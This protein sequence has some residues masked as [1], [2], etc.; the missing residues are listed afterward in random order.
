MAAVPANHRV[1]FWGGGGRPTFRYS[2][3]APRGTPGTTI[4][5]GVPTEHTTPPPVM[6]PSEGK[7]T[8]DLSIYLAAAR[9][10]SALPDT[11]NI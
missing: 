8:S 9:S 6:S 11:S 7:L 4:S 5:N 1:F 2:G 3:G 10:L